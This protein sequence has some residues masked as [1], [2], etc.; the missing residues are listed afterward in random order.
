ML[1]YNYLYSDFWAFNRS[2]QNTRVRVCD[3]LKF[4]VY[5]VKIHVWTHAMIATHV[6]RDL[7]G[8]ENPCNFST[9][10]L[11]HFSSPVIR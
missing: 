3:I 6:Y 9:N 10:W 5:Y 1:N 11:H 8:I 2:Q 4:W 7:S